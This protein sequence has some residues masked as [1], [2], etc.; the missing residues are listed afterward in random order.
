MMSREVEA[1]NDC[2]WRDTRYGWY[3]RLAYVLLP[4]PFV[5][6]YVTYLAVPATL[7]LVIPAGDPIKRLVILS[8]LLILLFFLVS[9]IRALL[10]AR[11]I[12]QYAQ[13]AD[14]AL[15]VRCYWG[16]RR[17]V[18]PEEIE[19]CER[20]PGKGFFRAISLIHNPNDNFLLRLSDG[21]R[22]YFYGT[23]DETKPFLEENLYALGRVELADLATPLDGR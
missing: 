2:V 19:S 3:G 7:E 1:E 21:T 23:E 10:Q 12:V 15:H 14:G 8:G 17:S 4:T 22:L 6:A 16:Y 20:I 11:R 13:N 5:L 9:D 18:R